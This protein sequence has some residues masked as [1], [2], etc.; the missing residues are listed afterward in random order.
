[1]RSGK[2][3]QKLYVFSY[4]TDSQFAFSRANQ[5]FDSIGLMGYPL[6]LQRHEHLRSRV[7][8]GGWEE[9]GSLTG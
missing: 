1:M 4:F 8:F 9:T 6:D 3:Y 2:L 7:L 5:I